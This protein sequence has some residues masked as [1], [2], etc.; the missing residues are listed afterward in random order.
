MSPVSRYMGLNEFITGLADS[1]ASAPWARRYTS[2]DE[3]CQ[4]VKAVAEQFL[5]GSLKPSGIGYSVWQGVAEPGSSDGIMPVPALGAVFVPDLTIDVEGSPTVAFH[6][7]AAR[8]AQGTEAKVGAALGAALCFTRQ[9]P[10][11]IVFLHGTQ[12]A[13]DYP[14]RDR[15]LMMALW[16]IHKIR[17]VLR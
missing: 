3:L 9:Y 2:K 15:E 11:V 6:I 12:P 7:A 13:S 5:E 14:L 17:L 8:S 10:A 16:S 4:A 1:L